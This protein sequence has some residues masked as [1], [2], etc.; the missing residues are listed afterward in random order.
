MK[1]RALLSLFFLLPSNLVFAAN[2]AGVSLLP[3]ESSNF[4]Y[5]GPGDAAVRK[6]LVPV[7]G[8]AFA[9]A[10]QVSTFDL[11][12]DNKHPGLFSPVP[13]AVKKGDVLWITLKARCLESKRESGEAFFDLR[14]DRLV[15]SKYTWPPHMERGISVSKD[16]IETAIPFRMESDAELGSLRLSITMDERPQRFEI[17][18]ITFLN[19]GPDVKTA[20]LP[21]T[22]V[23]Y[24]GSEPD[25]P[26]RKAA[27]ERIDKFRKGDLQIKVTDQAGNALPQASVGI[28]M[29][30]LAFDI[31]TAVGA[32]AINDPKQEVYREKLSAY[33]NQ[34]VFEN[35]MKWAPWAAPDFKLE[36]IVRALDWL[37]AQHI[38]SRA[39]VMVWPSWKKMPP[40]MSD[41]KN[42]NAALR[43][44]VTKRIT[45]QTAALK[46]RFVH[47]DV[48][49]ELY[50]HHDLTDLLGLEEMVSWYKLAHESA[51]DVRLFY[52]EY[53][54]FH[55]DGPGVENFYNNVKFLMEKGAPI[56]GLGEQA[57]VAG[58]P[59]G[60]PLILARL[61][62]FSSF[63]VPITITEFDMSV[64][65][66]D[67]QA[68]YMRDF[69]TAIF[70][71]PTTLGFVQW[72]FWA[73]SHWM[74]PAALW[75]ENW[76]MRKH[77]QVFTDI[78]T[79]EW[80]TDATGL[81]DAAGTFSTRAFIGDY[82]VTITRDGKSVTLPL[83]LTRGAGP[84]TIT[85][86]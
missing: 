70:S 18:P 37:D 76:N 57:H 67:F 77:G 48:S 12:K 72:G 68:S 54:M 63:G 82:E 2:P 15:N 64:A 14:V 7:E 49:N 5:F 34:I 59:P 16:W 3:A 29:K 1:T 32:R 53:T 86:P 45:D 61:D 73:G 40:F 56:Q 79:K 71:H 30:R 81:T 20:D 26:W 19:C 62:R 23:Q 8:Q 84:Q 38:T 13:V 80:R 75:D 28:K 11:P 24:A 50:A 58:S 21:R 51:P 31:G 25:A 36:R 47:W 65:D 44:A 33:F 41:L 22:A 27:A 10:L 55:P 52:N 43:A 78:V 4:S 17:G 74:P 66:E 85:L 42:D 6:Q 83:K 60:I 9:E 35:D 46:D 69:M 39:H